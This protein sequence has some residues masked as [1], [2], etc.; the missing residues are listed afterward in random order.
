[1]SFNTLN[2]YNPSVSV[3]NT[4]PDQTP[5]NYALSDQDIHRLR[6]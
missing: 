6:T 1:M 5:Q 3:N 4:E 2:P